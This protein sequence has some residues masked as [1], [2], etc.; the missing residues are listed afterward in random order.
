M[1]YVSQRRSTEQLQP[2]PASRSQAPA[3]WTIEL[4]LVPANDLGHIG[5]PWPEGSL[6]MPAEHL[7]REIENETVQRSGYRHFDVSRVRFALVGKVMGYSETI[8]R[9]DDT[10]LTKMRKKFS[11]YMKLEQAESGN[12]AFQIHIRPEGTVHSARL[13]DLPHEDEEDFFA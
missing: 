6:G 5:L 9:H 1:E 3:P 8:T 2:E 11:S 10:A 13:V 4:I 12:A 7:F